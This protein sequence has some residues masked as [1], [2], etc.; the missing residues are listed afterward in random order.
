MPLQ[1]RKP[2]VSPAASQLLGGQQG[3]EGDFPTLLC[4]CE[5]PS[6]VMCLALRSPAQESCE[7]FGENG[8][9]GGPQ[10]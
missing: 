5:A 3:E 4:A 1:P 9:G 7:T 6:E 2:T 10:G 8:K